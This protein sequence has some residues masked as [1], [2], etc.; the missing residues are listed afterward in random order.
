MTARNLVFIVMDS[1]RHDSFVRAKT[2]NMDRI[3]LGEKRYSYAS[4]TSPS[5]SA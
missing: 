4:W 2:P 1:C 3:G 5:R